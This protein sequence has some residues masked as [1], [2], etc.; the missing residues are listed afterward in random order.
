MEPTLKMT[1]PT[2]ATQAVQGIAI[3]LSEAEASELSNDGAAETVSVSD[4]R[5][6]KPPLRIG[7]I[8]NQKSETRNQ[9]PEI[10]NQRSGIRNQTEMTTPSALPLLVSGF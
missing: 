5:R 1:M 8:R 10:R 6:N 7:D 9:K 4:I 3:T 2:N